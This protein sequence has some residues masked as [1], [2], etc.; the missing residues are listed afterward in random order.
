MYDVIFD[1]SSSSGGG[2]KKRAEA[3]AAELETRGLRVLFLLNDRLARFNGSQ[4]YVSFEYVR[5]GSFE[6]LLNDGKRV[7][8]YHGKALWY[9]AYGVPIYQ[10]IGE[11]NWYHLSNVLP[12]ARGRYSAPLGLKMKM[13]LLGQRVRRRRANIDQFSAESLFGRT[14]LK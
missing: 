1:F 12:F 4:R 6:R 2:G 3:Y 14:C 13:G 11:R 8:H 9:F 7:Q 5:K 10:K